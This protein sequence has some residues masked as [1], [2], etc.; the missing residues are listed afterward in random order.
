MPPRPP[1]S[2]R[3]L[4]PCPDWSRAGIRD[5][6]V[7][8]RQS[9]LNPDSWTLAARVLGRSGACSL[10]KNE[11]F[12]AFKLLEIHWDCQSYH[13]HVNLYHFEFFRRTF[14]ALGGGA[15]APRA[16]PPPCL[17]AWSSLLSSSAG[18]VF[19]S[20]DAYDVETSVLNSL[21]TRIQVLQ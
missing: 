3:S 18:R 15:C 17:R 14:L 12:E 10:G 19:L 2:A 1:Y 16:P 4:P 13:H 11:K 5:S 20:K 21:A 9:R 7:E 8:S 6:Q